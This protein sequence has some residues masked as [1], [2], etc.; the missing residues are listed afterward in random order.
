MDNDQIV[1]EPSKDVT[2][3]QQDDTTEPTKIEP[4]SPADF[5]PPVSRA[6]LEG[7]S[8]ETITQ[9]EAPLIDEKSSARQSVQSPLASKPSTPLSKQ[10]SPT[11]KQGVPKDIMIIPKSPTPP[12][13]P[14]EA[15]KP[16]TPTS[17]VSANQKLNQETSVTTPVKKV[18]NVNTK[19]PITTTAVPSPP[20]SATQRK[21]EIKPK[22]MVEQPP[23]Q[24][25]KESALD[26]DA[27]RAMVTKKTESRDKT[28]VKKVGPPKK[29]KRKKATKMQ[30]VDSIG[31]EGYEEPSNEEFEQMVQQELAKHMAEKNL[32]ESAP[33]K[34]D[35]KLLKSQNI[36]RRVLCQQ[37]MLMSNLE[38]SL[39]ASWINQQLK[40]LYLKLHQKMRMQPLRLKSKLNLLINLKI[41]RIK[42]RLQWRRQR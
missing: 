38:S 36:L 8:S 24:E 42:N 33:K 18:A 3:T 41:R 10:S 35:K 11:H 37:L 31:I 23:P 32:I 2:D 14:K 16:A 22:G 26:L 7:T 40:S 30:F 21:E 27:L 25:K 28:K 34:S 15:K 1:V 17:V 19:Q 6:H 9:V 12:A 4:T 20:K 13:L 5:T 39:K 29:E